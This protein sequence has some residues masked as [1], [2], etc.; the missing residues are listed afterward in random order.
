MM[1]GGGSR[2]TLQPGYL[3]SEQ[4]THVQKQ[5]VNVRLDSGVEGMIDAQFIVDE[6]PNHTGDIIK[7]GQTL[8]GAIIDIKPKIYCHSFDNCNINMPP[9]CRLPSLPTI[10][11]PS[12]MALMSHNGFALL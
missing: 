2:C 8:D 11:S 4:A 7:K 1:L 9:G 12:D 3:I 10:A 6:L 5:Y